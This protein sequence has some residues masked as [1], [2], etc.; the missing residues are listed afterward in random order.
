MTTERIVSRILPANLIS[1]IERLVPRLEGWCTIEKALAMAECVCRHRPACCIEIGVH[2]GRSLLPVALACQ[3]I[4]SGHAF[5]IDPWSTQYSIAGTHDPEHLEFWSRL[6]YDL[7][8]SGCFTAVLEE[9]L[10]G[11]CTLLRL[12]AQQAAKLFDRIDLLH[13]DGNHSTDMAVRDVELYLPKVQGGG[14]IWFDDADW[15]S[16]QKAVG[17]L[18]EECDVVQDFGTHVWF[19]KRLR[20]RTSQP[21]GHTHTSSAVN[22]DVRASDASVNGVSNLTAERGLQ[23][24]LLLSADDPR[25]GGY[26]G[27]VYNPGAAVVGERILLLARNERF[28]ELDRQ[29][30]S[31]LWRD[32]CRPMA[33]SVD[34]DGKVQE[35]PPLRFDESAGTCRAEDFRLFYDADKLYTSYSAVYSEDRIENHVAAVDFQEGQLGPPLRPLVDFPLQPVEKN[36]CYFEQGGELYAIYSFRPFRILKLVDRSSYRFATVVFG[37]PE[38]ESHECQAAK[39]VSL[40]TS[41]VE[42]DET[43]FLMFVHWR[44]DSLNYRHFGVLIDRGT[45]RPTRM[46]RTPLF[47]GGRARGMH[48]HVVYL[49]SV[50]R[51]K[52]EYWMFLGEGDEHVSCSRLGDSQMRAYLA[53]SVEIEFTSME[54]EDAIEGVYRYEHCGLFTRQVE[55]RLGGSIANGGEHDSDWRIHHAGNDSELWILGTEQVSCRMRREGRGVWTGEWQWGS[56][57][58]A[59]LTKLE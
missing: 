56:R 50:L 19:R 53:D 34:L 18:R 30:D 2:G 58:T 40:S 52:D 21:P 32:S 5:G 13:I 46:A 55:L 9:N 37:Y 15:S 41:P 29:R 27:G 25:L 12:P 51:I 33:I 22:R 43:Q 45:L 24:T 35:C 14:H 44:G 49:M 31:N 4:G 42:F 3:H 7:I 48:P 1:R 17:L 26:A 6:D 20:S 8:Y 54:A 47:T 10:T 28:T 57:P 23:P 11:Y 39:F 36:W 38:T 59:R 16:T